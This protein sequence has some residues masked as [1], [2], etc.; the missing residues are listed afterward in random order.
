M[1]KAQSVGVETP[2]IYIVD[3]E[4]T[5]IVMERVDGITV[6]QFLKE[7]MQGD[8]AAALR[9]VGDMGTAVARMHDAQIIHGDLTTS[10][11]MV[12]NQ[13]PR[14]IVVIDFGLS[15]SESLPEEKAVDLYVLEQALLLS[16]AGSEPL[17]KEMLRSYAASSDKKLGVATL[18]ELIE[19]R[20]RRRKRDDEMPEQSQDQLE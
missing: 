8:P 13:P 14:R 1:V 7:K 10:N 5:K 15:F 17:V 6:E 11:F 12:R 18:Q 16:H 20:D 4:N 2:A 3:S 19:V 9:V